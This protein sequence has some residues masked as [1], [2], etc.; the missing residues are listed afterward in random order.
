MGDQLT[1]EQNPLLAKKLNAAYGMEDH[2]GAEHG[3]E[4]GPELC[5]PIIPTPIEHGVGLPSLH[6]LHYAPSGP[7]TLPRDIECEQ[8]LAELIKY[9]AGAA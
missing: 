1:E 3:F 6:L 5:I 7:S 4:R 2:A 9:Y 8:R